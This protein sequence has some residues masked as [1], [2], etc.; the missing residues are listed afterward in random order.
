MEQLASVIL[1]L[2][3]LLFG[4]LFLLLSLRSQVR[5]L[6]QQVESM[7]SRANTLGGRVQALEAQTSLLATPPVKSASKVKKANEKPK[8]KTLVESSVQPEITDSPGPI[9]ISRPTG[10]I[11]IT[12]RTTRQDGRSV[13]TWTSERDWRGDQLKALLNAYKSGRSSTDI[14]VQLGVDQKDVVYGIARHVFKCEGNLEDVDVAPN[15][16][17]KWLKR[18]DETMKSLLGQG[19]RVSEVAFRLG[20][21]Q[22]AIIW[23]LVG[24]ET[25]N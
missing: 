23:R 24:Q 7:T 8:P 11:E 14:A 13:D 9:E 6:K 16:G 3:L 20:R 18:D 2:G 25:L 10:G 15:N 5:H 22:L 17:K 19:V 1:F 4:L 12:T 21:T